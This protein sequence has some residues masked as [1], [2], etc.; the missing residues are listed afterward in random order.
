[1]RGKKFDITDID[2]Q[3][4]ELAR[5]IVF[6]YN[7]IPSTEIWN[8]ESVNST[9]TQVMFYHDAHAFLHPDTAKQLLQK[10]EELIDHIERQAETGL[11]F[12]INEKPLSDAGSYRM[13]NNELILGDNTIFL[14]LDNMRITYLVHS[15]INFMTTRDEQ[16]NTYMFNVLQNLISRSSQISSVGEKE[17]AHFFERIREKLAQTYSRL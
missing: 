17:R 12:S 8:I 3:H 10:V 9:I 13:F 11:K 7:K 16:F 6:W 2:P 15:V 14:E 4:I 1:M 5:K